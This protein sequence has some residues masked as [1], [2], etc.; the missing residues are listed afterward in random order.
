LVSCNELLELARRIKLHGL[1]LPD[2][3]AVK[4]LFLEKYGRVSIA[5]KLGFTERQVRNILDYL[6]REEETSILLQRVL[7]LIERRLLEVEEFSCI[8]VLYLNL[9]DNLLTVIQRKIVS[10]RD[11]IVIYSSNP[12]KIEILGVVREGVIDLPGL[13]DYVAK[14]YTKLNFNVKGLTGALVCWRDYNESVDDAIFISSL[15][16]LCCLTH[17]NTLI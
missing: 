2:L 15:I 14:R 9:D 11:Y 1:K 6:T 7:S 16:D 8:P 5:K 13:P 12:E 4:M 10:L 3:I 17:T